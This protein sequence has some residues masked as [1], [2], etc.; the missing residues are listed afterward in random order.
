MARPLRVEY[1]G[2]VYHVISRGNKHNNIYFNN[3]DRQDFLGH[4]DDAVK[5]HNL[6]CHAYCLMDNHYHLLIETPDANLSKAMRDINGNYTQSFNAAHKTVG[7][8][9]QGRYK[10]F[11]IEK[12]TYLLEVARY[13]VLNPVRAKIVEHP[14]QWKWSSYRSTAES[15]E[16]PKWLHTDWIIGFFGKER[17]NGQINYR[18][19]IKE[20]INNIDPHD[21]VKNG[22]L[23]GSPQFISWIWETQTNGSEEQ[24]EHPR[25]QRIVGR[26]ELRDLFKDTQ[27]KQERN[28]AIK[29][30]RYRCGYLTTEIAEH[31]GLHRAVVGRISREAK[32]TKSS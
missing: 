16:P 31:V 30:A 15:K 29:F 7:H 26:P 23:L 11:V 20:G 18:K 24:K 6:I 17:K 21:D 13:I 28:E 5:L 25:E 8:L 1:S 12:E 9:F 27:T 4:V 22:F 2:A 10:A 14:R 19:F 3:T 32:N